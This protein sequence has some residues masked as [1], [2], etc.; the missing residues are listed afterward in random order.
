MDKERR[1]AQFGEGIRDWFK[2]VKNKIFGSEPSN[3]INVPSPL[4][5]TDRMITQL[6]NFFLDIC[7]YE[8]R[9]IWR[10]S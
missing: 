2:N 6:G 3:Q 5:L 8:Y 7:K 1:N 9:I 10:L 4:S